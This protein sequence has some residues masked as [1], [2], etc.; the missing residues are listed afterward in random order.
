METWARWTLKGGA[1]ALM[2]GA[3][4]LA[5]WFPW[6]FAPSALAAVVLVAV[7]LGAYSA[8][9]ADPLWYGGV[10]WFGR[11]RPRVPLPASSMLA[12]Q[13]TPEIPA[14]PYDSGSLRPRA[15]DRR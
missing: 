14:D 4:V 5:T 3:L 9:S 1:L 11:L 8:S 15:P 2:L 6:G 12:E 7:A 10:S 13:Y